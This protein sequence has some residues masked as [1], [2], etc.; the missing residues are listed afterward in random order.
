[1]STPRAGPRL[2]L[3]DLPG[4]ESSTA[5][6]LEGAGDVALSTWSLRE[7]YAGTTGRSGW[8][9]VSGGAVARRA[10]ARVAGTGPS[11]GVPPLGPLLGSA[12]SP[13]LLKIS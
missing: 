4:L 10:L 8:G 12:C 6:H 5:R 7:G 11:G 13:G 2:H 9:R 1:M 3:L